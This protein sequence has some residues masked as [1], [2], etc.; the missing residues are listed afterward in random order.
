M[1]KIILLAVSVSLLAFGCSKKEVVPQPL[2]PIS[3]PVPPTSTQIFRFAPLSLEFVY[4]KE[5]SF[6]QPSFGNLPDPVT[7]ISMPTVGYEKTNF[8][9]ASLT[10][11]SG[12]AKDIASCLAL[13]TPQNGD[14]FKSSKVINGATFYSTKTGGAAAGSFYEGRIYRTLRGSMCIEFVETIHTTNIQ[15]YDP[16]TVTEVDTT[17]IWAKLDAIVQ[18]VKFTK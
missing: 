4:P 1:K 11:T 15:N 3:R 16:G 6:E 17:P 12:Y 5:F 13:S 10:V 2:P 14:G 7:Q 18:T 9:G 8:G